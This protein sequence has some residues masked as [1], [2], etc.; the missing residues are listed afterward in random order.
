MP[1]CHSGTSL[2]RRQLALSEYDALLGHLASSAFNLFL[3][4][5]RWCLIHP[6]SLLPVR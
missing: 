5:S 1:P 4:V 3:K 6:T 2:Q